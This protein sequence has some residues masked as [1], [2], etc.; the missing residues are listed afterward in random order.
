[1]SKRRKESRIQAEIV[2]NPQPRNDKRQA[3]QRQ[4]WRTQNSRL[5]IVSNQDGNAQIN[6]PEVDA[7]PGHVDVWLFNGIET[8][9]ADNENLRESSGDRYISVLIGPFTLF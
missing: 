5:G 4:C 6:N 1:M 2:N 8:I 3:A 7:G 9:I